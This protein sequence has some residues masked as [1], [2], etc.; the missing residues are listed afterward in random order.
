MSILSMLKQ[1][2]DL[3][4]PWLWGTAIGQD[5]RS[6]QRALETEKHNEELRRKWFSL[7]SD[8]RIKLASEN[9]SLYGIRGLPQPHYTHD[10]TKSYEENRV[11][12]IEYDLKF[13]RS[14]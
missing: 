6:A 11:A 4:Q 2:N 9:P 13:K 3:F 8:E 12:Q 5:L 7:S 10:F 1:V 14:H